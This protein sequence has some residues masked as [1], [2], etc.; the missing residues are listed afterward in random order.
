MKNINYKY[1]WY[2]TILF[3]I[4]FCKNKM[5]FSIEAW[6]QEN[7]LGYFNRKYIVNDLIDNYLQPPICYDSLITLLGTPDRIQMM[8]KK[9]ELVYEIEV[10]YGIDID[11]E[12]TRYLTIDL[13]SD[14]CFVRAEVIKD[15]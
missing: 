5:Q 12:W 8:S 13:N 15:K 11:P 1:L 2:F 4:M 10:K 6:N 7:D 14:S 3:L 9:D